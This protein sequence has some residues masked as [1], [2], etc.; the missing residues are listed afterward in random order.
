MKY[1]YELNFINKPKCSSCMLSG[2]KGLNL[3]GESVE[4]CFALGNRPSCPEEGH[5][6]DCPLKLISD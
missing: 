2:I 1:I 6:R 4:A 5:H 3:N